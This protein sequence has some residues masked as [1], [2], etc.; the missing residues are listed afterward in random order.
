[1]THY[2]SYFNNFVILLNILT[3]PLYCLRRLIMLQP[4][5]TL[6]QLLVH[7]VTARTVQC[8][9]AGPPGDCTYCTV[10][11][12]WSTRPQHAA[13]AIC[14]WRTDSDVCRNVSFRLQSEYPCSVFFLVSLIFLILH[15]S[16][17]LFLFLFFTYLISFYS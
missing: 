17:I 3:L 13:V 1:M 9:I 12:C 2:M 7:R 10:L 8:C 14:V 5:A 11:Y 6:Q 15:I 4:P 16:H